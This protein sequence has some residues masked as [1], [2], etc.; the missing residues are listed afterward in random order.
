[1]I[2]LQISVNIC[3]CSYCIL[4]LLY[5]YCVLA[6]IYIICKFVFCIVW[7]KDNITLLLV[8]NPASY[9]MFYQFTKFYFSIHINSVEQKDYKIEPDYY[10]L[11]EPMNLYWDSMLFMNMSS[12]NNGNR[13]TCW[14]SRFVMK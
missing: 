1:M 10:S 13:C 8:L 12:V 14:V 11:V 4:G 6:L 7:E 9:R 2:S 3:Y 5:L